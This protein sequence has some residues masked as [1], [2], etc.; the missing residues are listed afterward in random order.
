MLTLGSNQMNNE[1]IQRLGKAAGFDFD[2][3]DCNFYSNQSVEFF[4]PKIHEL[5]RL[6][7]M[8]CIEQ[9]YGAN[10]GDLKAKSYYLDRIAEHIENHF[11]IQ[12]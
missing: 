1:L 12:L 7:V 5:V 9:I 3:R 8:E 2:S 4:N 6:T 10:V 11:G